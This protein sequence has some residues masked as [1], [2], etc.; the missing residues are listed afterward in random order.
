M[1]ATV[2]A[3]HVGWG[4]IRQTPTLM[5][6]AESAAW[7]IILAAPG[8]RRNVPSLLLGTVVMAAVELALFLVFADIT[9][10]EAAS[11]LSYS[12]DPASE[13]LLR[14]A[15]Y[16]VVNVLPYVLPFLVALSLHG[17]LR[18]QVLALG[19][20]VETPVSMH[21]TER[22]LRQRARNRRA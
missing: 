11:R 15:V 9:A 1:I 19:K 4:T 21:P 6:L 20:P 16:L 10:R 18:R 7:A 22:P 13:W 5:H 12:Q 17:E 8:L 3:T 2:S 14:V